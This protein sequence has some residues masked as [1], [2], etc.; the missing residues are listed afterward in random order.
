MLRIGICDE[1]TQDR[2]QIQEIVLST[3]FHYDEISCIEYA[4]AETLDQEIQNAQMPVDL[5][6]MEVCFKHENGLA[7]AS[8]IREKELDLD[9]IF[10]TNDADSVYDGYHVQAQ[11]YVLKF[12]MEQELSVCLEHYIESKN[13]GT[14]TVKSDSVMKTIP[15]AFVQYLESNV[16]TLL[17]HTKGE[18]IRFYG[19]LSDMEKQLSPHGFL[20][21]HQSFLV[22][23]TAIR[24]IRGYEAVVGN[25]RLPISRKYYKN[26]Q[27]QFQPMKQSSMDAD[28][29]DDTITKSLAKRQEDNGAIIGT[30]GELLGIIYRMK[31][32]EKL[33]LG[34]DAAEC[35]IVLKNPNISR[36]HCVVSRLENENYE[37]EDCSKNG[38]YVEGVL[39]G[40]GNKTEGHAGERVWLCDETLEFRLG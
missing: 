20:R 8:M 18:T 37:I 9:I 35:Q 29:N 19:K 40:K 14:L 12:R 38:V 31:K 5:L 21:I 16:R 34:R 15:L 24:E 23:K 17:L 39:L 7:L 4:D 26:V 13:E 2:K 22:K 36:Q 30:K 25:E 3:M 1:N 6:I 11:G 32:G 27:E 10:V 28:S 33:K